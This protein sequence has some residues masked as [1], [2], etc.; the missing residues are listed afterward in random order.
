MG[1]PLLIVLIASALTFGAIG[2]GAP[3]NGGST[4]GADAPAG[5]EYAGTKRI[6]A[7]I[8]GVPPSLAG[9]ET[10]RTVASYPG[11]DAIME[12]A[13]AALVHHDNQGTLRPQLA[14]A[15]PSLENGLWQFL[16]EGGMTT[17]LTIKRAARWHDGTP[18]TTDDLR[19]AGRVEQDAEL[20]IPRARV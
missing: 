9:Q 8:R 18:V 12:L 2:C 16:P 3:S 4:A 5:A 11:L 19:L 7:V 10:N 17:T 13:H 15:T 20:G 14:E 6:D 1:H